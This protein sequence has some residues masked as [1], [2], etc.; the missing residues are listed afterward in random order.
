MAIQKY[1]RGCGQPKEGKRCRPCLLA[2]YKRYRRRHSEEL[3]GRRLARYHTD[4]EVAVKAKRRQMRWRL[5]NREKYLEG[6]RKQSRRRHDRERQARAAA[7]PA[8]RVKLES[9]MRKSSADACT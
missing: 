2:S 7:D 9:A 4:S 6:K 5:D 8:F 3:R 1:C